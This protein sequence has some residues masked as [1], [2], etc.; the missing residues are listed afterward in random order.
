LGA[1]GRFHPD[2]VFCDIGLP[3]GLDGYAVA[4]A[5]RGEPAGS[6]AC[7]IALTGYGQ[8]EDQRRA[9]AAGFDLHLTKPVDPDA[10]EQLL[11]NLPARAP[12]WQSP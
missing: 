3:G 11:S 6:S 10:L 5:L 8:E 12:A 9:H 1:A 7:L 4:R 2:I